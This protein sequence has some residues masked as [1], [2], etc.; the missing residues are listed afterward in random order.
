M[1]REIALP[2]AAAVVLVPVAKPS[3]QGGHTV[4]LLCHG[5]LGCQTGGL[6]LK[7]TCPVRCQRLPACRG[8]GVLLPQQARGQRCHVATGQ[9]GGGWSVGHVVDGAKIQLG[10]LWRVEEGVAV[11]WLWGKAPEAPLRI[12]LWEVV[13]G[14]SWMLAEKVESAPRLHFLRDQPGAGSHGLVPRVSG[15]GER[16]EHTAHIPQTRREYPAHVP[17]PSCSNPDTDAPL[18]SHHGPMSHPYSANPRCH[19]QTNLMVL[20]TLP[21]AMTLRSHLPFPTGAR[22][23]IPPLGAGHSP[24]SHCTLVGSQGLCA[25]SPLSTLCTGTR[26]PAD[27]SPKG[28]WS[29]WAQSCTQPCPQPGNAVSEPYQE[30]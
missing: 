5:C 19:H 4:L 22:T 30:Y 7:G 9:Q 1:L 12:C 16:R 25:H 29:S 13:K 23:G 11:G 15:C 24:A 21:A 2:R 28:N 6:R 20:H 18:P 17:Q 10:E 26:G 8:V 27:P 3:A 14:M